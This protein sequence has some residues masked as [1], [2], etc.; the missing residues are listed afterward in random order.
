MQ[1]PQHPYTTVRDRSGKREAMQNAGMAP[2]VYG[3]NFPAYE[4]N[5]VRRIHRTGGR[6]P[7]GCRT[8][9]KFGRGS[10]RAG[11]FENSSPTVVFTVTLLMTVPLG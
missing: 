5:D 2:C 9:L 7:R 8:V 11:P 6:D 10:S 3:T 4:T 1:P